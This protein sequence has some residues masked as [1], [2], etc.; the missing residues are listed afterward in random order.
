MCNF[1]PSGQL[2]RPARIPCKTNPV[3]YEAMEDFVKG[4]LGSAE[5][6]AIEAHLNEC[7][8]CKAR[9]LELE[10][11]KKLRPDARAG[12]EIS[13]RDLMDTFRN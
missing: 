8:Y 6:T 9:C 7:E 2:E 11:L 1:S 3:V 5:V 10:F 13:R 12:T 4:M